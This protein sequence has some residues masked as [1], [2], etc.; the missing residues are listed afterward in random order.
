MTASEVPFSPRESENNRAKEIIAAKA[1]HFICDGDVIFMD[2]S[3]TTS[4]LIRYLPA[5]ADIVVITN[6]PK[7]SLRLAELRIR[8]I[9]TG[10]NLLE[11]SVAFIGPIAEECVCGFNADVCFFSCRGVSENGMLTDSSMEESALRL[12]M[13]RRS[14]K[15]IPLCTG[16]KL[17][18]EYLYNLCP[19]SEADHVVSDVPLPKGFVTKSQT[20]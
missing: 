9:S 11:N 8:S 20:K 13:L 12:A 6:S 7:T 17:G 15:K 3:S 16:D 2:A 14:K 1:R 4:H 19:L 5:F 18:K 10:G